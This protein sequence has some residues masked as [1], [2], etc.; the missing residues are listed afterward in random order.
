MQVSRRARRGPQ[1]SVKTKQKVISY[2]KKRKITKTGQYQPQI[3][4]GWSRVVS[5]K[6]A[7]LTEGRNQGRGG[8]QSNVFLREWLPGSSPCF[9]KPI[10]V[11][12][13]EESQDLTARQSRCSPIRL[14]SSAPTL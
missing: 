13:A 12:S 3:F 9:S 1:D 11:Q 7:D 6:R 8:R 5:L 4:T 10:Q 14:S 2:E